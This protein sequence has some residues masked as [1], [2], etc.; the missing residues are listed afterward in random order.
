MPISQETQ[1][2]NAYLAP[3]LA[4]AARIRQWRP[5][6]NASGSMFGYLYVELPIVMIIYGCNLMIGPKGS[7]WIALPAARQTNPDGTPRLDAA[8]KQA[9]QSIVDF[10]SREARDKFRD[11]VLEAMRR[12]HPELFESAT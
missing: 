5:L 2:G 8:G 12:A 6:R 11:L 10:A 9:W 1:R 7:H 4:A 3:R